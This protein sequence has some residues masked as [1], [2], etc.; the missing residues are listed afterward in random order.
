LI[1]VEAPS[2]REE[3]A[4]IGARCGSADGEMVE[5]G[6]TPILP[7]AELGA[8]GFEYVVYPLTGLLAAARALERAFRELA[9]KGTS[10]N[11]DEA[12]MSFAE[13]NRARG[14]PRSTRRPSATSPRVPASHKG[15]ACR[16]SRTRTSGPIHSLPLVSAAAHG[17]RVPKRE[18]VVH[19]K[20]RWTYEKLAEETGRM[21]G[22]LRRA[23][24]GPGDR[25]AI[26]APNTPAHWWLTSRCRCSAR[27][28]SRSTRASPR[29]EIAYILD[30]CG[31]KVLLVDPELAPPLDAILPERKSLQH[32]I[33][34]TRRHGARA[35]RESSRGT[36]SRR[37]RRCCP[38]R[39]RSTTKRASSRSIH[40]GHDR[41]AEGR[42]VHASRAYLNALSQIA[43]SLKRSSTIVWTVRVP[44]QRLVM[45]WAFTGRPGKHVFL[46]KVEPAEIFRP[47]R[48]GGNHSPDGAPRCLDA[49]E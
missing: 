33:G 19:G 4:R 14:L 36:R 44:L 43:S 9:A 20:L 47:D 22:A 32:V 34:D 40:L 8:L 46:R 15:E 26:L 37:T 10:R 49:G 18:A 2:S 25:V 17:A 24:V 16:P 21:A 30:H 48:R 23:G 45:P 28:S 27:R 12:R 31:A 1:F 3:L 39:T 6:V 42:D 41:H 13:F 35:A 7:L 38:S 29:P 5:G 11:D